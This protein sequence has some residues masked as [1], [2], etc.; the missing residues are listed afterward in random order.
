MSSDKECNNNNN[1]AFI[2]RVDSLTKHF[3]L[4]H[5][6]FEK[7]SGLLSKEFDRGL[8][9]TKDSIVKMYLTYVR[10]LPNKE[11]HGRYL[12]L[13]LGGTNIRVL[14][15]KFHGPGSDTSLVKQQQQQKEKIARINLE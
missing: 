5:E 13:D 10:S 9:S 11:E 1:P 8:R 3:Q 4:S 14:L 15:L 7:I 6:D 2:E 12:A